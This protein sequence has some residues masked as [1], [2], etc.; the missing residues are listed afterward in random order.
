LPLPLRVI[1]PDFR[2]DAMGLFDS[3]RRFFSDEAPP[4]LEGQESKQTWMQGTRA[5]ENPPKQKAQESNARQSQQ[6]ADKD[7]MDRFFQLSYRFVATASWDE[8]RLFVNHQPDLLRDEVDAVMLKV[9]AIQPDEEA[10][11]LIELHRLFLR[12]S[13]KIGADATLAQL[14]ARDPEKLLHQLKQRGRVFGVE[15]L[16]Q[17]LRAF[18]D[19]KTLDGKR[20]LV[21]EYPELMFEVAGGLLVKM[22]REEADEGRRKSIQDCRTLLQRCRAVGLDAA[23][24][25]TGASQ[26]VQKESPPEVKEFSATESARNAASCYDEGLAKFERGL[27]DEALA[28]FTRA[29][30]IDPNY[31][32]A[33]VNR[34]ACYSRMRQDD[35]AVADFSKAI[36]LQPAN[37]A[38]YFN[39][40]VIQFE[41]HRHNEAAA[42]FTKAIEH[43][44]NPIEIYFYRGLTNES[45]GKRQDAIADLSLVVKRH[46]DRSRRE[47]ARDALRRLGATR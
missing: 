15:Q 41:R 24:A 10:R 30:E 22:D 27:D 16:L 35:Q 3:M 43:D 9:A 7:P 38:A 40:G 23:F 44:A 18:V 29:I 2:L 11:K 47:M 5:G 20:E 26:P 42:D 25:G 34:G 13:K 32:N 39:R 12:S 21:S 28:C 31:W 17:Q 36:A 6:K 45:R 33:Y 1:S 46:P 8:A 14:E 4:K 19:A 37:A